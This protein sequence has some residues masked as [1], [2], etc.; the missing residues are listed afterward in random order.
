ML[1]ARCIPT[2][3]FMEMHLKG[4]YC[5]LDLAL[6]HKSS[7]SRSGYNSNSPVSHVVPITLKSHDGMKSKR[8]LAVLFYSYLEISCTP[9]RKS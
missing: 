7:C 5:K 4:N 2:T 3:K 1:I 8:N 9:T 6:L